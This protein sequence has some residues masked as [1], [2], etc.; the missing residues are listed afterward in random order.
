MKK[1]Y[2]LAAA[3]FAFTSVNAQLFEDDME[4]YTL[5]E[6]GTQNSAWWT[7]WTNDGGASND[8]MLVVDTQAN[9]G[10]KSLL[11]PGDQ[12]R[13]PVLLLGNQT[14]G[15]YSLLW[16]FYIPSGKEG[17][18]NIQGETPPVGTAFSGVFNSGNIYFNEGNGNPN[19]ITDSNPTSDLSG[20]SFPHDEWFTVLLYVDVDALTY[21]FTIGGVTS[22][23]AA[24]QDDATL[25]GINYFPGASVSEMY[26]DDVLF[27]NGLL[28]TNDFDAVA[29]SVYPNPVQD[30]LNI[31]TKEA[32][33]NISVY[34]VLGKL[35]LQVQPEAI[36]P[37]ID[38]G[39]LSSGAYMV[40]VTIGDATKTVKVIK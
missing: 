24:F 33:Q 23:D 16:Y 26:I 40:Q 3:L 36:S 14:S 10:D 5:G 20:L 1:I 35:V 28:G 9:S 39:A 29:L 31:S 6:M 17:Y 34:D 15:D 25:G 4:F 11:S 37:S 8:G 38:M 19:G 22:P 18:L 2:F 7:S 32:V 27:D 13:D 21:N 12:G 30:I